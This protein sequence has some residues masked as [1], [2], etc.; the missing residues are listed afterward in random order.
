MK[1][2][3]RWSA[4]GTVLVLLWMGALSQNRPGQYAQADVQYGSQIYTGQCAAC[5]GASGDMVPGIDLRAGRFKRVSSDDDLRSA[6]SA[7]V[8]GTAMPPFK[9]NASEL[10]GIVAYIRTMRDFDARTVIRGDPARGRDMFEGSGNCTSCH[11][12]NGSGSRVAPDLSDI[13]AVRTADALQRSL[14]DP[15]GSMLPVNRSVRA[16]TRGGKA[17]SGRRLNE[18][19]YTVQLIDDQEHLVSLAKADLREYT[20]IQTSSM[21]SYKD[22]MSSKDLD[23]VVAYLLSLKALNRP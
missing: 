9:F 10:A 11:R 16:V 6:V 4:V 15:T 20:V 5:H 21:P 17:I 3:V 2:P 12:V 13:G 7:G 1:F 8:T 14:L 18:D 23:D 19:T 22:R